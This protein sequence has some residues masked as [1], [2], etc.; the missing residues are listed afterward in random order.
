MNKPDPL[1]SIITAQKKGAGTRNDVIIAKIRAGDKK[2]HLC[3]NLSECM[4]ASSAGWMWATLALVSVQPAFVAPAAPP[5]D[6][7]EI[8]Q[9]LV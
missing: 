8:W 3:A 1:S 2:E 4:Q 5:A 6:E 7:R 9:Q